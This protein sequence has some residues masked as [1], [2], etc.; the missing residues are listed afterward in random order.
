MVDDRRDFNDATNW[1]VCST[2][3]TAS[4]TISTGIGG[5]VPP[6]GPPEPS[7]PPHAA[8][9]A[10]EQK[11]NMRDILK[12]ARAMVMSELISLSS[13]QEEKT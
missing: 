12:E 2:G 3:L 8:T 13:T 5:K 9:A 7:L 11:A 4:V 10:S 1:L 6:G